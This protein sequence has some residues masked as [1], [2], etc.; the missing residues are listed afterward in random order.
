MSFIQE[1]EQERKPTVIYLPAEI[2]WIAG[3]NAWILETETGNIKKSRGEHYS[4]QELKEAVASLAIEMLAQLEALAAYVDD[5]ETEI[6]EAEL[7]RIHGDTPSD[8]N[9]VKEMI[10]QL[11]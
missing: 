6:G 7:E 9:D 10:N 3:G 1:E 4:E 2:E 8:L 11:R 5:I